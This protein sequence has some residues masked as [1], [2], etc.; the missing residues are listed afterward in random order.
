MVELVNFLGGRV[1]ELYN[2][3]WQVVAERKS[4]SV[5]E[6]QRTHEFRALWAEDFD[7]RRE[8]DYILLWGS[9]DGD[10]VVDQEMFA[11]QPVQKFEIVGFY[12]WHN[13]NAGRTINSIKVW[14]DNVKIREVP[15]VFLSSELNDVYVFDDPFYA[16]KTQNLRII[17]NTTA[18]APYTRAI[19]KGW[20]IK[21]R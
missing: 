12:G 3:M 2:K 5:D 19:P 17:P 11:M 14:V 10:H 6:A 1:V 15:G 20:G 9:Y 8:S 4:I 7:A 18:A 13:G 21:A 16:T